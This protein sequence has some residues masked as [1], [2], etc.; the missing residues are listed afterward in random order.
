MAGAALS[1]FTD[2]FTHTTGPSYFS[3][4]EEVI[5]DAQ[6]RNFGALTAFSRAKKEVQGGSQIKDMIL[7]DDPL[8]AATYNPGESATI[9][10]TQGGSTVTVPWR[11]IRVYVTWPEAEILL[12]EGGGGGTAQFHQFKK[13]RDFKW[14]QGWT[15]L[16]NLCERK[17]AATANNANMEASSGKEPY[18]VFATVTSDGL[19]P[20]G[21]TTV[22]GLNPTAKSKWRNQNTTY[23]SGSPFDS[24]VG[25][26]AGFDT[27]SQLIQFK[28]PPSKTQ[29]FDASDINRHVVATNREGRIDYMKALRAGNDITRAGPQDPAYNSPVFSGIPVENWEVLDDQSSFSAA[30]PHFLFLNMNYLK[31][32]FHRE[33]FMQVG[34]PMTFP[35][36]P[37][38]TV[39]WIDTYVNLFNSSRSRHGYLGT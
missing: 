25:I 28:T 35:D 31:M 7:L 17:M 9:T 6:L 19:A 26:I 18:S 2:F 21:F 10:N 34:K 4:P 39:V 16:M 11:F 14:Q 1:A 20:T 33:K 5:N 36:K 8:S 12:N 30:S 27:L 23:T 32:I 24:D 22:Q 15:S 3:G 37:D 29:Y 13:L 38:T